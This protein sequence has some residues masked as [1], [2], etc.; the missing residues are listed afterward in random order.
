[1]HASVGER[2]AHA[3]MTS[4]LRMRDGPCDADLLLAAGYATATQCGVCEGKG[5]TA[6][7]YRCQACFGAGGFPNARKTLGLR[8]YRMQVTGD[9]SDLA[10]IE[11]EAM[12]MLRGWLSR[13]GNRPMPAMQRLELVRTVLRW[14]QHQSCGYC[15]GLGFEAIEYTPGLSTVECVACHGTGRSP[16]HRLLPGPL[17]KAGAML[18]KELDVLC[19]VVIGDMA[20]VLCREIDL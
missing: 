13:G 14:W 18:A 6:D 11:V 15:G 7:G 2:Y 5:R 19:A 1:M 8:I 12:A 20:D 17:V 9:M 3:A 10:R 4:N 16:L